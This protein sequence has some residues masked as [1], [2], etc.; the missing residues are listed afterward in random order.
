MD[1]RHAIDQ[2]MR[3]KKIKQKEI[4]E[5]LGVSVQAVS[6]IVNGQRG[7]IPDSLANLLEALDLRLI[8]IPKDA[9]VVLQKRL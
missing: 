7:S 4:A 9:D 6:Q 1:I 5:K 8:A 3:E 2:R